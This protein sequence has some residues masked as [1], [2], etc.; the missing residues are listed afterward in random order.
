[1]G[2]SWSLAWAVSSVLGRGFQR[3]KHTLEP[4]MLALMGGHSFQRCLHAHSRENKK[5]SW[6]PVTGMSPEPTRSC[7]CS[8][9][10]PDS[11]AVTLQHMAHCGWEAGKGRRWERSK[12][13]PQRWPGTDTVTKKACKWCQGSSC[14]KIEKYQFHPCHG[15]PNPLLPFVGRF[16]W[17]IPALLRVGGEREHWMVEL[18]RVLLTLGGD[19][20]LGNGSLSL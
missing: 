1:M 20:G 5:Q 17:T 18:D 9:W 7:I 14:P 19:V 2:S 12:N 15:C 10:I 16:F 6:T 3:Q 8:L 13:T 4:S 11:H